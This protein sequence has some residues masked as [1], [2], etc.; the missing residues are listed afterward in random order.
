MYE[1]GELKDIIPEEVVVQA[2]VNKHYQGIPNLKRIPDFLLHKP[3]SM[4]NLAVIE[5]KVVLRE[6]VR[7][8]KKQM[9]C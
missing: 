2:E 6:N 1:N 3:S 5:F 8:K 7:E 9:L 4:E